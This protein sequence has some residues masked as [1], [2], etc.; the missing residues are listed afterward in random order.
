M[1]RPYPPGV[2]GPK[3]YGRL[4]EYGVQ[5]REKQKVKYV[6]GVMERQFRG[7]YGEALRRPGNTAELFLRYLEQRL[8]NVVYRLGMAHSRREARQ[9]VSHGWVLVNGR[10]LNIPSYRVKL[11]DAV[12][13]KAGAK[14]HGVGGELEAE[15][16]SRAVASWLQFDPA[17]SS[18]KVVA[19]PGKDDAPANLNMTLVVEFYSR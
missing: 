6:Y 18:A 8:D 4:T 15:R 3:G 9:L 13:L 2:H 7:Y 11:G 12:A 17:T 16:P 1:R 14:D 19:V 5:L 10:R